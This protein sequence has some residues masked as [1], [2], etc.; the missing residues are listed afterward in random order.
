M[1]TIQIN[2]WQVAMFSYFSLYLLTHY[3]YAYP[4]TVFHLHT[5]GLMS[6]YLNSLPGIFEFISKF[7]SKAHSRPLFGMNYNNIFS[8]SFAHGENSQGAFKVPGGFWGLKTILLHSSLWSTYL[9]CEMIFQKYKKVN[10]LFRKLDIIIKQN[11]WSNSFL[12]PLNTRL[13]P[14]KISYYIERHSIFKRRL[15][16]NGQ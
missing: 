7:I 1:L 9:I 10:L 16:K 2:L 15:C 13:F 11:M 14:H 5:R 6:H 8:V 4:K 3:I 12:T